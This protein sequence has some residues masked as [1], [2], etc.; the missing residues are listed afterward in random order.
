[1]DNIKKLENTADFNLLN[2]NL[3]KIINDAV[4]DD[5]RDWTEDEINLFVKQFTDYQQKT[6][7][8][9]INMNM[10]DPNFISLEDY[11]EKFNGFDDEVLKYMAECENKK[12]EDA[13]IPPLIMRNESVTLT[14]SLSNVILNDEKSCKSKTECN[15]NCKSGSRGFEETEEEEETESV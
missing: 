2:N 13:R 15:S 11:K 3:D 10:L 14:D 4:Y 8:A 5:G 6:D 7:E 9:D 12:L 1:M